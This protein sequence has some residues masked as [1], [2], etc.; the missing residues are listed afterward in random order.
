MSLKRKLSKVIFFYTSTIFFLLGNL[1]TQ[2][3]LWESISSF[4]NN[5]EKVITQVD[6]ASLT[7]FGKYKFGIYRVLPLEENQATFKPYKFIKRKN[8]FSNGKRFIILDCE[9]K[10]LF[11]DNINTKRQ[12]SSKPKWISFQ[13][14]E[15]LDN[16]DELYSSFSHNT[17]TQGK[18][19]IKYSSKKIVKFICQK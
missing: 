10:K 11:L 6:K 17:I 9:N 3:E 7:T 19:Q 13:K 16:R 2:A 5:D 14:L 8:Y 18:D 12:I 4:K 15:S 1:P